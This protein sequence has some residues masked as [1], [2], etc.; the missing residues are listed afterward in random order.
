MTIG[1]A[2]AGADTTKPKSSAIVLNGLGSKLDL[3]DVGSL[4]LAGT[5]YTLI[6][7]VEGYLDDIYDAYSGYADP[8]GPYTYYTQGESI[9]YRALQALYLIP[10]S[11][12]VGV[13]H[14]PMTE[15]E[16][17]SGVTV[18][19]PVD[20][21]GLVD[22][23]EPHRVR[24]VNDSG[25]NK[26]YL[27]WRFKS[28]AAAVEY[29]RQV[30]SMDSKFFSGK[31]LS[32]KQIKMLIEKGGSVSL[33][34]ATKNLKGN[35]VYYNSTGLQSYSGEGTDISVAGYATKYGSLKG[36][37]SETKTNDGSN[38]LSNMFGTRL[39]LADSY[40]GQTAYVLRGPCENNET[41]DHKKTIKNE[42]KNKTHYTDDAG[43]VKP[44]ADQTSFSDEYVN[45]VKSMNY[46]LVLGHDIFWNK[47]F[48]NNTTYVFIASNNVTISTTDTVK[49]FRGIIIAGGNVYLP[50]G[51]KMECMGM[52]SYVQTI[53]TDVQPQKDVSEFQAL[54]DVCVDGDSEKLLVDDG[55]GNLIEGSN[56]NA[57]T[58]L[59]KIFNVASAEDSTNTENGTD[60]VTILTTEWKRN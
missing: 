44:D 51:L 42:A 55:T 35:A 26:V 57:N 10:G 49:G 25:N 14:N 47:P 22:A 36:Y 23:Y 16:Y 6:S 32:N 13:G 4:T 18:N 60:F 7:N 46:R 30:T 2:T 39:S 20:M 56:L 8:V 50:D 29:F 12:I 45:K 19:V 27:F 59:R 38:L 5:A 15:A 40:D 48:D 17:G 37:A 1:P 54:L 33:P 28:T 41:A 21:A 3:H 52:L 31:D 58:V 53:G 34:S 24:Y 43:N 11:Q 9:T